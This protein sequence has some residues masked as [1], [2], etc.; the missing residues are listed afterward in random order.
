M[1]I[2]YT[3]Y[4]VYRYINMLCYMAWILYIIFKSAS[5]AGII[6]RSWHPNS[7]HQRKACPACPQKPGMC[8]WEQSWWFSTMFWGGHISCLQG[9]CEKQISSHIWGTLS[10]FHQ[11]GNWCTKGK[12]WRGGQHSDWS[13]GVFPPITFP[14]LAVS[15][16]CNLPVNLIK[17][18]EFYAV[19]GP[20][21]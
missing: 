4:A 21:R 20:G 16:F 9:L 13:R 3:V 1:S 5:A 11:R 12:G 17:G 7:T 2:L 14:S 15:H 8:V 6:A 18:L 10:A 19:G